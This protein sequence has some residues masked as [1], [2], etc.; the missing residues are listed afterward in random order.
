MSLIGAFRSF[1]VHVIVSGS[2]LEL[3]NCEEFFPA[4]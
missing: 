3:F 4:D 2:R 1:Q